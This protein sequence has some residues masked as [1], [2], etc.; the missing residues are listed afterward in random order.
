MN[1]KDADA[2][3]EAGA[4]FRPAAAIFDMDGLMLDTERPMLPLWAKAGKSLGFDVPP[5]V[6]IRTLGIDSE[7]TRAIITREMGPGF[8]YDRA[9]EEVRRLSRELF[10]QGIAL[11]PG[12]AALLDHLASRK[13]PTAVATSTRRESAFRKLS[14]AGIRGRFE[15]LVGGDEVS[16]GKPAPDIFLKAAERLGLEPASCAGFEDSPAGLRALH[17]AGMRSVFVKDLVEP[18]EEVLSSVWKRFGNL[19]EAAALFGP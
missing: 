7:G 18:P 19:A 17:A 11:R 1:G 16:R 4:V 6:I 9:R 14:Q 5:D 3:A 13:I 15:I 10:E 8:P 2:F 12:L